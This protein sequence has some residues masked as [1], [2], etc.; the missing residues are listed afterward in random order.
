MK[1]FDRKGMKARVFRP[2]MRKYLSEAELSRVFDVAAEAFEEYRRMEV[3]EGEEQHA[4]GIF[5][6]A[7]FYKGLLEVTDQQTAFN[8]IAEGTYRVCDKVGHILDKLTRLPGMPSCFIRIFERM[9][10]AKF[11]ESAGFRSDVIVKDRQEFRMDMQVCPYVKYF[12]LCGYPELCEISCRSDEHAYG[13][14]NRV[15]FERSKTLGTGG[16]C[17]DFHLYVRT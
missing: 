5:Y 16:D 15:A 6:N 4:E 9:T 10:A 13:Q 3:P 17:C 11:G 14:M 1:K 8:I 7:A 2:E 12:G